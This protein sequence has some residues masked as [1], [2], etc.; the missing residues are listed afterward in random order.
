M[1]TARAVCGAYLIVAFGDARFDKVEEMRFLGGA[2]NHDA[3]ASIDSTDLQRA[4]NDLIELLKDDYDSASAEIL[5]DIRSCRNNAAATD[6]VKV[7]ARLAIVADQEIQPQ[8]EIVLEQIAGALG[9]D[10]G[11]L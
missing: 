1:R 10:E 8:E 3:F 6:A 7:A 2:T 11:V 4:Y 5:D 9:L